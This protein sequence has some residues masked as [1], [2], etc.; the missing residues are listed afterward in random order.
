MISTYLFQFLIKLITFNFKADGKST[1]Y[2]ENFQA[3]A[4]DCYDLNPNQLVAVGINCT[5]PRLIES[6]ITGINDR[7]KNNPIPLI[8]Y[9]N[10]GESYNVEQG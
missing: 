5:A 3:V 4:R 7:R 1:A 10:S 6:L 9:P 2:G 8:V